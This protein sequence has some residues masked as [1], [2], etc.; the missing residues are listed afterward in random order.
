MSDLRRHALCN[1][2]WELLVRIKVFDVGRQTWTQNFSDYTL[3]IA[4]WSGVNE[5]VQQAQHVFTTTV[6][7][8]IA[9][10]MS[11]NEAFGVRG[12]RSKNLE[13]SV[14]LRN[15]VLH[16]PDS[17]K[18]AMAEL[19]YNSVAA[20]IKGVIEVDRVESAWTVVSDELHTGY[21]VVLGH[22]LGMD[23]WKSYRAT[24]QS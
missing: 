24:R 5:V 7:K 2:D 1:I 18:A 21:L 17:R 15:F 6:I 3:M 20:V 23:C 4:I 11:Q 8:A 13:R 16:K 10:Q 19:V 14:F 12:F 9:L 22:R